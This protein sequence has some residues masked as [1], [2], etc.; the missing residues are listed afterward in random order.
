[1]LA[2]RTAGLLIERLHILGHLA[3]RDDA[4]A[5]AQTEGKALGHAAQRLVALHG[6]HR[7]E[8][9]RDLAVNEMLQAALDLLRHILACLVINESDGNGLERVRT[10]GQLAHRLGAP[11]QAALFG[12]IDL[13]IGRVIEAVGA[14]M[15]MGRKGLSA[16]LPE[17]FGLVGASGLVHPEAEPFKT[18]DE[19]AVNRHFTLVVHVGHKALLL[20]EPAK[21]N[22]RPPVH[23]SLGQRGM[24]R[25]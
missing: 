12:E 15:E 14:Q 6:D 20:L 23:K 13:G 24:K 2:Q 21:E 16:C 3:A 11:H 4:K 5:F 8:E 9:G 19:L 7:L 10:G 1:M 25:V 17:G 22:T 18:T